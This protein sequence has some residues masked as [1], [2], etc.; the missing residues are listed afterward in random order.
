MTGP[1]FGWDN[2]KPTD[3]DLTLQH[4]GEPIG[5]RIIVSGRV[6]D[7]NGKAVP[8]TLLEVWHA[9]AAGRYPPK[10]DPRN[11]PLDPNFPGAG[12]TLTDPAGRYRLLTSRPGEEP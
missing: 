11:A 9:N 5:E 12:H 3:N 7:E 10:T 2:I 1:L 6:L 8:R 4:K